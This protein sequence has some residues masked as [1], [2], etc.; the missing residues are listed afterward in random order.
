MRAP[1][2][3]DDPNAGALT[4]HT[5]PTRQHGVTLHPS[6]GGCASL[7]PEYRLQVGERLVT[8][9]F[10]GGTDIPEQVVSIGCPDDSPEVELSATAP[11][12]EAVS[13]HFHVVAN[14]A[15]EHIDALVGDLSVVN[16]CNIGPAPCSTSSGTTSTITTAPACSGRKV[17]TRIAA[18]TDPTRRP[19]SR[20]A[21]ARWWRPMAC[22][23]STRR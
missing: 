22:G 12:D 2:L 18:W 13:Q 4:W 6:G 3:G 17:A 20:R 10:N 9:N 14:A 7:R 16:A 19:R 15:L 11:S 21:W 1:E 23:A 8:Y 5:I